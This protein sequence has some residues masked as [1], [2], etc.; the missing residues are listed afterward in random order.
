MTKDQP[1]R[2]NSFLIENP[3]DG[4]RLLLVTVFENRIVQLLGVTRT[5]VKA[6]EFYGCYYVRTV[7]TNTMTAI[8]E[9]RQACIDAA[10][11][12]AWEPDT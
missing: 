1:A 10:L 5:T 11:R 4:P 12:K 2:A 6:L 8:D 7:P 3:Y 9:F